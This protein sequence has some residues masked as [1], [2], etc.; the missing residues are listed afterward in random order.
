MQW[1]VWGWI[2]LG[3]SCALQAITHLVASSH[4]MPAPVG[5]WDYFIPLFGTTKNVSRHW[6]ILLEAKFLPL[7]TENHCCNVYQGFK[8]KCT[9]LTS[10]F[11]FKWVTFTQLQSKVHQDLTDS[12]QIYKAC[13]FHLE[14]VQSHCFPRSLGAPPSWAGLGISIHIHNLNCS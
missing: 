1:R 6:P 7:P 2:I 13:G 14:I 4:Q 9:S 5:S 12:H 8:K 10:C 11:C 3:V